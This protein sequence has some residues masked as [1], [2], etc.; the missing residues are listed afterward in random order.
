MSEELTLKSSG[1]PALRGKIYPV[2]KD[3]GAEWLGALSGKQK[4]EPQ[5]NADERRLIT[6][7]HRKGREERKVPQQ[8]LH[9]CIGE[10]LRNS[11]RM[12]RIGR[13]YTD[14]SIREHPRHPR[15]PC[16]ITFALESI[17]RQQKCCSVITQQ[18]AA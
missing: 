12:T 7:A 17:I 3:S 4:Q 16:S 8:Y 13:I 18:G 2:Y 6:S 5:I 11:T 10:H 9:F 15:N 14:N 1:T